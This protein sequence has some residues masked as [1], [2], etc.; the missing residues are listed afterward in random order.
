MGPAAPA[1]LRPYLLSSS[2]LEFAGGRV[3]LFLSDP[4]QNR[5]SGALYV[6]PWGERVR[7]G[8]SV[9]CTFPLPWA[10]GH[11]Q[12]LTLIFPSPCMALGLA[13][14]FCSSITQSP[15]VRPSC[16]MSKSCAVT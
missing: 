11:R 10:S 13:Y 8:P 4:A 16:F 2:D 14:H 7:R 6:G 9:L 5:C 15:L 3:L 12:F 1:A